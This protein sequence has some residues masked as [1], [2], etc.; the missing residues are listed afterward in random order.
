MKNK[1]YLLAAIFLIVSY[2]IYWIS[3]EEAN[4][5]SPA[6]TTEELNIPEEASTYLT[7]AEI[8]EMYNSVREEAEQGDKWLMEPVTV[9][10]RA[11]VTYTANEKTPPYARL[12]GEGIWKEVKDQKEINYTEQ[13][14]VKI[15]NKEPWTGEGKITLKKEGDPSKSVLPMGDQLVFISGDRKVIRNPEDRPVNKVIKSK[16]V[17][18]SGSGVFVGTYGEAY[19]LETYYPGDSG[20][21]DVYIYGFYKKPTK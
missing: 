18:T 15:P 14:S 17:F 16:I 3:C 11:N 7:T 9:K 19:K 10:I 1:K 4:D 12:T 8:D 20:Y 2:S 5:L 13:F 21:C 6:Y